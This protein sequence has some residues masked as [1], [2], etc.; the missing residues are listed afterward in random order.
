M[1]D[2]WFGHNAHYYLHL[3]GLV[4]VA[5]GLPLSKVVLSIST[6]FLLLNLLLKADFRSYLENWKSNR[7]FLLVL[8]FFLLHFVGLMWS[9]DI[10]Y[11][12]NDIWKKIPLLIIPLAATAVPFNTSIHRRYVLLTFVASVMI[13]S[14][15]NVLIYHQLIGNKEVIEFRN[16]SQ[17]GSHVRYALLVVMAIVIIYNEI[18]QKRM[19]PIAMI[20]IGWLTFYTFYSQVIAG[21]LA[22][23]TVFIV[24]LFYHFYPKRKI[25]L[26]GLST[27]TVGLLLAVAN[28][29]FYRPDIDEQVYRSKLDRITIEG[30][31]YTHDLSLIAPETSRPIGEYVCMSE[32]SR[33][34][35]EVSTLPLN[36]FDKRKQ[37]LS[38]TLIRYMASMELRKD[39][40]GFR[41]LNKR[42]IKKIENGCASQYCQGMIARLYG[43]KY[44]IL[45]EDDPNG[46][47]LLQRLEYWEA[48]TD[49]LAKNFIF[50]VGTGDIQTV[51]DNYYEIKKSPL[52]KKN[53][54]R[55]HNYYLTVWVT[56]G[57]IGV[58]LFLWIHFEFLRSVTKTQ[59]LIGL[60]FLWILLVSYLTEDTLE[61]QV[62]VTFFAFFLALFIRPIKE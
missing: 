57:I 3:L 37:L 7:T 45:N 21:F 10:S 18:V 35:N 25:I 30:N 12:L 60:C 24:V 44:Q 6:L 43:L 56:F 20:I 61:T 29:L 19:M 27:L 36:G 28:W 32:L 34:W 53:R 54:L 33:E 42:D 40:E 23:M 15:L 4:G 51:F 8:C 38:Q 2:R 1:L 14:I 46:H 39:A 26:I 50:G 58:L 52:N 22:L 55:T 49:L 62:G 47:S 16:M 59:N 9:N 17:F 41:S 13:T 5:V 31:S 48:G 11:G